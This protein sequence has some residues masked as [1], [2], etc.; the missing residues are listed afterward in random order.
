MKR[1][2]RTDKYSSRLNLLW[3]GLGLFIL[4]YAQADI[5]RF[6]LLGSVLTH[7]TQLGGILVVFAI[8]SSI[9]FKRNDCTKWA[10]A[11]IIALLAWHTF[12]FVNGDVTELLGIVFYFDPYY[13]TVYLYAFLL[14]IPIVPLVRSFFNISRWMM[15]AALPLGMM[16]IMYYTS[17]GAIQFIFEGFLF[18]AALFVMTPKYHSR[19]WL[20]A[21]YGILVFGLLLSAITARRNLM[22]T[23]F[24]YLAAGV[25]IGVFKDEKV[26]KWTKVFSIL[27]G[28]SA[29]LIAVAFFV[30]NS[31]GMFANLVERAGENTREYVLL[32]YFWDMLQTPLDMIIGRGVRG[33]YECAGI[34][35][36]NADNLRQNVENGYLQ[37]MLKGGIIYII[38]YLCTFI[39]AIRKAVKSQNQLCQACIIILSVQLLDMVFFGLH[40]VNLKTF[41]IWMCVSACLSAEILTKND[42]ELL[43]VI[44]EKQHRLPHWQ[45]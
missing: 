14:L 32:Y 25:Y 8:F 22:V 37:L 42:N 4:G 40:A 18:G 45:S 26:S 36:G 28:I 43:E 5:I 21:A 11:L 27:T 16:P 35:N 31:N 17:F 10:S 19:Q 20:Y 34:E 38:I 1:I 39:T 13:Y 23:V 7:V 30:L 24:L 9:Q 29:I 2:I 3:I 6:S 12:M 15:L 41:M 44:T 33:A